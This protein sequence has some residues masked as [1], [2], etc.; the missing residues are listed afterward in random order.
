M[1]QKRA[2]RIM[3]FLNRA[4]NKH[5]WRTR[6]TDILMR[7]KVRRWS[8]LIQHAVF[9]DRG[10]LELTESLSGLPNALVPIFDEIDSSLESDEMSGPARVALA[11]RQLLTLTRVALLHT[12]TKL[13]GFDE[14]DQSRKDLVVLAEKLADFSRVQREMLESDTQ[15][16]VSF[17]ASRM[18]LLLLRCRLAATCQLDAS[19]SLAWVCQEAATL[20]ALMRE[21][22][23]A[24]AMF[25]RRQWQHL[26]LSSC[27]IALRHA[28]AQGLD[29]SAVWNL[30]EHELRDCGADSDTVVFALL[31]PSLA[32]I[33]A[34]LDSP[35]EHW[36]TTLIGMSEWLTRSMRLHRRQDGLL[37]RVPAC[38]ATLHWLQ[39][40]LTRLGSETRLLTEVSTGE[41]VRAYVQFQIAPDTDSSKR[42][43]EQSLDLPLDVNLLA[44]KVHSARS[45]WTP[46]TVHI[47]DGL[48][49]HCT[50]TGS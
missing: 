11:T 22:L 42:C 33:E 17:V 25:I 14:V 38:V 48:C 23:P 5:F 21:H 4:A 6:R 12:G 31:A 36:E 13:P 37:L 27:G 44:C 46:G 10:G 34:H 32:H 39:S 30:L 29:T 7:P 2:F 35:E 16:K 8:R 50:C 9:S 45:I 18:Q 1:T 47:W 41:F 40:L 28:V 26:L 15:F 3:Q 43:E 20:F 49:V 19:E 24:K